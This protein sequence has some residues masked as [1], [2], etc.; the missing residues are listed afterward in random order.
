MKVLYLVYQNL[1]KMFRSNCLLFLLVILSSMVSTFGIL[2]FSGYLAGDYNN[3]VLQRGDKFILNQL[4]KE[5]DGKKIW[6]AITQMNSEDITDV[7]CSKGQSDSEQEIM[8]EYHRGYQ[9]RMLCGELFGLEE[10]KPVAIIDEMRAAEITNGDLPTGLY[11]EIEN[12]KLEVAGVCTITEQDEV[13]VPVAYY[14]HNLPVQSIEVTLQHTMTDS[15]RA[16][17]EAIFE[18]QGFRGV[19]WESPKKPWGN[20]SFWVDFIQ[21]ALIFV[22]ICI[23]VLILIYYLFKRMK[24]NFCI[25]SVC[26]GEDRCIFFVIFLQTFCH[27]L[28][29]IVL[30]VVSSVP[31]FLYMKDVSWLLHDNVLYYFGVFVFIVFLHMIFS[32]IVERIVSKE[33]EIYQ[34]ME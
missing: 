27:L 1:K 11:Y 8:G 3:F 18:K 2:F 12:Q 26:G 21:I 22:V 25:Y 5:I 13:M 32:F 14:L 29:G 24:R 9:S 4:S 10:T 28:A 16:E 23:N 15:Q 19:V 6:Q 31:F 17:I 7:I 33:L 34:V 20:I 30:G